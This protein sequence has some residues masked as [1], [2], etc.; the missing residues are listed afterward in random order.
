[1]KNVAVINTKQLLEI[2]QQNKQSHNRATISQQTYQSLDPDGFHTLI[3][4]SRSLK[5]AN[6][7]TTL[8]FVKV[9]GTYD[10]VREHVDITRDDMDRFE[11][12][13]LEW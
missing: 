8:L 10:S 3:D 2:D 12:I 13:K 6:V 1:M 5:E 9:E 11:I 4:Y 7:Y